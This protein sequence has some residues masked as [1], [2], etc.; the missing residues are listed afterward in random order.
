MP[1]A[2]FTANVLTF[3]TTHSETTRNNEK[4]TRLQT[5]SFSLYSLKV[6]YY[7]FTIRL[8]ARC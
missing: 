7:F 8:T 6:L 4:K 2:N 3:Q 5:G 1:T